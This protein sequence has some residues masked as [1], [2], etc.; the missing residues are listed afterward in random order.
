MIRRIT[1]HT[2][3][4]PT[5]TNHTLNHYNKNDPSLSIEDL[6]SWVTEL[7]Q[8]VLPIPSSIGNKDEYKKEQERLKDKIKDAKKSKNTHICRYHFNPKHY[9]YDNNKYILR[10]GAKPISQTQSKQTYTN[11]CIA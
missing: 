11:L 9:N 3:K 10:V 6:D 7:I 1:Q 2:F 4:F 8:G 5:I